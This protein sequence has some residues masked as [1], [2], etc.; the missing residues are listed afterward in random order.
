MFFL[1]KK[2]RRTRIIKSLVFS[3]IIIS[4]SSIV[5]LFFNFYIIGRNKNDRKTII[6]QNQEKGN[7]LYL[8]QEHLVAPG[9][10]FSKLNT[11]LKLNDSQLQELIK[12][13]QSIYDLAHI[14][15]GNKIRSF[16]NPQNN[17]FKKLEYEIDKDNVLIIERQETGELKAIKKSIEYQIELVKVSCIV[18]ESLYQ[19]GKENGLEDKTIMEMADIFAWDI[20]FGFETKTG[21]EFEIL[22]EKKSLN[23]QNI[24]PGRI[25]AAHYKNNN[26]DY[27]AIYYQDADGREDYY[28]LEGRCLRRQFLKAPLNYKYISSGYSLKRFHPV[29]RVYTTHKSVDY[30]AQCGTPVSSVGQGTVIFVGWKNVYGKTVEIRHNGVYTTRYGHLS[31]YAKGIKYGAK[32]NQGQVIGYVG[33]TGSS[34]GCHLDFG[35]SKYNNFINP[36]IQNFERSDPVK[37]IYRGNFEFQKNILLNLLKEH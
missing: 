8:I 7:L 35:M 36:L 3:A 31:S 34:T 5:F 2:S 33:T 21:D 32:V 37:D 9:E 15:A 26:K 29:W 12:A 4:I 14:K 28:D 13:S 1:R 24:F 23:N 17:E 22:Y 27:W 30:A 18:K 6:A 10:I 11:P 19:A 20:D 25:L 16:F